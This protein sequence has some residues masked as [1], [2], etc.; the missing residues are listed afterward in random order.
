[1]PIIQFLISNA[2]WV[3]GGFLLTL[4]SSF[5]QTYFI[6]LSAGAIR[7]DY[8]LS[9]GGFGMIYM[10]ATLAS[11]L[12]LPQLGKLVDTLSVARIVS[13]TVPMLALACVLM[14]FSRSLAL[15][16]IAIYGLRLF[17][18]GMMTHIAMT[19]MGKWF[20]AQRG[21]AVS[22]SAIGINFAEAL[23]PLAFVFIAAA[24][25]W[26]NSWVVAAGI[27]VFVALP[28]IF[29]LMRVEREPQSTVQRA[30]DPVARNWT[31]GEVLRDPY[32]YLVL[33]GVLAP[34]FIGTTIFFHQV[35]LIDLRGWS[36][37]DF[38]TSFVLMSSMTVVCSLITGQLVDRFSAIHL[39]PFFLLPL[40]IA[41]VALAFVTAQSGAFIFM[42]FLG[43]SYGMSGTIFGAIWAE[44]YGTAH[45]GSI[46]SMI[47]AVMVLM[48]A[49]GPGVTGTLIDLG[50]PY[51]SQILFMGI[52][53]I[54]ASV[55]L[56]A[57]SRR[58]LA[59][60]AEEPLAVAHG[61]R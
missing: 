22:F 54:G 19:A 2:R 52:Y 34:S 30:G 46:R 23:F 11:A 61:S 32:F 49:M 36:Q 40:S 57:A 24:I 27:M 6:A 59:R 39:L 51:P 28:A 53:C 13:I 38:A 48:T 12:T 17:G 26:R 43:V 16:V 21:R 5:G 50:V 56:A 3:A 42:A 15:L 29:L 1:M 41:C 20:A 25:G 10:L 4:F 47:V 44:V 9:H 37:Q 60:A 35:Y 55:F 8:G 45:L 33:I 31:R 7:E 18:Q 58:F 14:A